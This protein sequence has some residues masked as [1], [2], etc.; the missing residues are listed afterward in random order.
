MIVSCV[1]NVRCKHQYCRRVKCGWEH[2][3]RHVIVCY[4]GQKAQWN[5][6]NLLLAFRQ[7]WLLM[8]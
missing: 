4:L 3:T 8:K 2:F 5:Q 7:L 1:L 6:M